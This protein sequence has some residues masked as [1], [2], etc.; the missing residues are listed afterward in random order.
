MNSNVPVSG[1]TTPA[2]KASDDDTHQ[3]S[4][5]SLGS[6][7]GTLLNDSFSMNSLGSDPAALL[8]HTI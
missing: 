4:M 1:S 6:D 3:V 2:I 7:P 8:D 5:N